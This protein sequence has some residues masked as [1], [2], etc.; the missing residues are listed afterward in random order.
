MHPRRPQRRDGLL[1][2]LHPAGKMA[3][4]VT[5]AESDYLFRLASLSLSSPLA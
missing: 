2:T 4:I 5:S 3:A 1:R